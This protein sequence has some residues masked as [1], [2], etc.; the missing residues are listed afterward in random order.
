[1]TAQHL[2]RYAVPPLGIIAASLLLALA[3][4]HCRDLGIAH[5]SIPPPPIEDTMAPPAPVADPLVSPMQ[6]I[7]DLAA[8][9]RL[10]WPA[11]VLAVGIMLA[12]ALR[13]AGTRWPSERWLSW[14]N[15]GSRSFAI[16]GGLAVATAAYNTLVEGGSWV[17]VGWAAGGALLALLMPRAT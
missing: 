12:L 3:I 10:G 1:M 16:A 15:T 17:A 4:L 6:A 14:I 5:A 11:L 13:S 9:Q 7:D 8:A 2:R